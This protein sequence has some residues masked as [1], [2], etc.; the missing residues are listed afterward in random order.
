[1]SR[2][3]PL[4]GH[5]RYR[6]VAGGALATAALAAVVIAS[7]GA[8]AADEP[9]EAVNEMAVVLGTPSQGKAEG[10]VT[11]IGTILPS[12][13]FKGA[14]FEAAGVGLRNQARGGITIN[15]VQG[16]PI[17]TFV[18]WA[19]ITGPNDRPARGSTLRISRTSPGTAT[20]ATV[21][22]T[23]IGHGP[24][25]CWG[26]DRLTV[27]RGTVKPT[28]ATGNGTYDVLLDFPGSSTKGESPWQAFP[29]TPLIE[30]A[31][32]VM[33]YPAN[34]SSVSVFDR[35]VDKAPPLSGRMFFSV[36]GHEL[37]RSVPSMGGRALFAEIGADGQTGGGHDGF[38]TGEV[39]RLN[40]KDIAGGNSGKGSDWDGDDGNPLPQ[41]WDTHVHDVTGILDS[42]FDKVEV[43]A[44]GDCLTH[45]ANVI[46]G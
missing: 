8:S 28:V 45:I 14:S 9:V 26:G 41:L 40:G 39:T 27:Y 20:T 43:Q 36:S 25:P 18:Y 22:G 3:I 30:G 10:A 32:L 37:A 29:G 11:D 1:M 35:A 46:A 34:D 21:F 16:T 31:S 19:E 33:V 12:A 38:A 24:S 5:R 6:R 44:G 42:T 7:A 2:H 23:P 17:T 15:G 4:S 13:E